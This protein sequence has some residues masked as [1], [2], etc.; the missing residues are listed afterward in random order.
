[1]KGYVHC[2]KISFKTFPSNC[3]TLLVFGNDSTVVCQ[4]FKVNFAV[5]MYTCID[6]SFMTYV[7]HK[8]SNL[9]S[10]LAASTG[11]CYW[12]CSHLPQRKNYAQSFTK[13]IKLA[14]MFTRK[15]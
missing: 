8:S 14:S 2:S 13:R 4:T 6:T 3:S 10:F 5:A 7:V 12:S 9:I 1:M 15:C 11:L